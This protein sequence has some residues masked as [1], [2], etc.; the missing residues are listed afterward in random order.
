M[1]KT[2]KV[3]IIGAGGISRLHVEGY[4]KCPNV[5]GL[6]TCDIRPEKV[7][8]DADFSGLGIGT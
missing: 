1:A 6:A 2:I 3:G 5:K 4:Q 8:E 7:Y